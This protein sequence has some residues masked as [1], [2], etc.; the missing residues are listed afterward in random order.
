[1]S[2][3]PRLRILVIGASGELGRAVVA[4]LGGRHE[5]VAAGSKSGDDPHRHRR[6][7]QHRRRPRGGRAARRGRLRRRQ[8]Q[9]R[10]ARAPSRPRRWRSRVYGL[11]LDQQADGPG[12]SGAGGARRVAR[13]RLDHADRRR[14]RRHAD[15][16]RLVGQHGQR[17]AGE[18]RR[19]RRRSKCRAAFA[20][21]RSARRCSR[22]RWAAMAPFFRGFDPVPVARAARAFSRSVEGRQTGQVYKVV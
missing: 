7:R 4:E 10:P 15:R 17:R 8:R 22:N 20:S 9:F 6:S 12:Q 19:A 2:D 11:G 13:R 16:R 18:L 14:A 21:T 5:I 3:A 1:M